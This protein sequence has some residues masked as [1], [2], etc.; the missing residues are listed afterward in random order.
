[1]KK[2]IYSIVILLFLPMNLMAQPFYWVNANYVSGHD[3]FGNSITTDKNNN[4]YSVSNTHNLYLNKQDD[5]G[6]MVWEYSPEIGIPGYSTI[7]PYAIESDT[8]GNIYLLL[9]IYGEY[10]FDLDTLNA[11]LHLV[12][13][14]DS[15]ITWSLKLSTPT[16]YSR[17]ECTDDGECYVLVGQDCYLTKVTSNGAISWIHNFQT[18]SNFGAKAA[19]GFS[20]DTI[21]NLYVYYS[22][23]WSSAYGHGISYIV[24]LDS[25]GQELNQAQITGFQYRHYDII[26]FTT[27]QTG[28]SYILMK[29]EDPSMLIKDTVINVNLHGYIA[30]AYDSSFN[31]LSKNIIKEGPNPAD[32]RPQTIT[33]NNKH[34]VYIGGLTRDTCD[35]GPYTIN[36]GF[37]ILK[38]DS[39]LNPN[40]LR[41]NNFAKVRYS[42]IPNKINK[43]EINNDRVYFILSLQQAMGAVSLDPVTF[44]N[45]SFNFGGTSTAYWGCLSDSLSYDTFDSISPIE[46]DSFISPSNNYTWYTSGIYQ[47]KIPNTSGGDSIITINLTINDLNVNVF[48]DDSLSTLTSGA[49]GVSYQWLNCVNDSIVLGATSQSFIPIT[50][51]EYA[52]EITNGNCVDTSA[53]YLINFCNSL[54]DF[55]VL[56][57]GNGNYS[58]SNNSTGNYNKIHWAFGDGSTSNSLSPNH[59]FNAN[60]NYVVVLTVADTT[61]GPNCFNYYTDSIT[62][63]NSPNQPACNSGFVIIPDTT[64]NGNLTIINSSTGT[65]LDYL[66]DFGDGT[67]SSLETPNHT[68]SSFGPF[69]LCLTVEDNLGC[70]STYC[71]SIGING[72][73]M[74]TGGGFTINVVSTNDNSLNV[75][76][77]YS[78]QPS[79]RIYPNPTSD[80]LFISCDFVISQIELV[81]TTGKL[82]S[83]ETKDLKYIDVSTLPAGNYLIKIKGENITLNRTFVKK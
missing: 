53:C 5:S 59:T 17:L 3:A 60:G 74:K 83:I 69:N 49:S 35:I 63:T 71:D 22:Q 14:T 50:P 28:V 47:D 37:F 54:S 29:L 41:L 57:N 56:D 23:G 27:S 46:C 66:W 81:T 26:N 64:G 48:V 7:T 51:G 67:L 79:L 80:K 68:Y 8:I 76:N 44:G 70:S 18:V 65:N 9:N 61:N 19:K 45:F 34:E 25:S 1:M 2:L 4:T 43:I 36:P 62:V 16:S 77:E 72:T 40:S 15:I 30:V 10:I 11:G 78:L 20:R 42:Y 21:G 13:M 6:N 32:V 52:V 58:F 73:M 75:A 24:K 12:K 39:I 33:V 31:F 38:Y 55:T 82:L